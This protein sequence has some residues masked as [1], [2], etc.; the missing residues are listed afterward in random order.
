M[1]AFMRAIILATLCLTGACAS[2]RQDARDQ[3]RAYTQW[4]Y[5]RNFEPLW[6]RFSPEMQ[7]TFPS[8]ESLAAF[9]GRTVNQLGREQG[10]PLEEL[11][12]QDT[13]TV[14]SRQATF[15]RSSH[16]MLLQWTL[17]RDGKVTGFLLRPADDSVQ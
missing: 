9:A 10:A 12:Q 15:E 14:Y 7:R 17:T 13:L 16:P 1:R 2:P 3:G 11:S 8:P 6:A 5:Q 4:F